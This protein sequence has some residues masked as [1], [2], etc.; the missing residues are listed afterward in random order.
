MCVF[1]EWL[2]R[3]LCD[4]V[5][6]FGDFG[7]ISQCLSACVIDRELLLVVFGVHKYVLQKNNKTC[8]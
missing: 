7:D 1:L 8:V 5:L 2:R 4:N 3:S 6:D